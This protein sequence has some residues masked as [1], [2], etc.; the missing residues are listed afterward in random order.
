MI[1]KELVGALLLDATDR[2][3]TLTLSSAVGDVFQTVRYVRECV[4]GGARNA[5]EEGRLQTID[6]TLQA[7]SFL[8]VEPDATSSGEIDKQHI[9]TINGEILPIGSK[10]APEFP[11]E[12]ARVLRFRGPGLDWPYYDPH[13]EFCELVID[14]YG[15]CWVAMNGILGNWLQSSDNKEDKP[16]VPFNFHDPRTAFESACIGDHPDE[17]TSFGWYDR[18][19]NLVE[20]CPTWGQPG[21][22][23]IKSLPPDRREGWAR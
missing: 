7:V 10:F 5:H 16:A 11:H 22:Q 20:Q 18:A 21:W 6:A 1:V 4:A 15:R 12:I 14:E 23:A 13:D 8:L 19:G 9:T 17:V 2:A 3:Y